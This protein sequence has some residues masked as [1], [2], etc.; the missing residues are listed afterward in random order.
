MEWNVLLLIGIVGVSVIVMASL[1]IMG[2]KSYRNKINA[3]YEKVSD[4]DLLLFI[5]E[6]PD[7]II[8]KKL[9][10]RTFDISNSQSASRLGS[11][12]HNGVLSV[13]YSNSMIRYSYTLSRPIDKNSDINLSQEPFMTLEDLLKIFKHYD[14]QVSMQELIL[15]TGLPL[16][17][18]KREMKYFEKEKIIKIMLKMQNQYSY[19]RLYMLNEPYRSNPDA[20]LKLENTN[21]ELKEIYEKV[22]GEIV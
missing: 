22:V 21:F 3:S 5:N 7:K 15:I 6:Q 13:L 14:H 18:I 1:I 9:V 19:Q 20:F 4:R 17:V 10:A 11:L 2:V 12:Q 16:K 8:D